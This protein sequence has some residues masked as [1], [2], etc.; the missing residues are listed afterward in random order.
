MT[1]VTPGSDALFILPADQTLTLVGNAQASGVLYPQAYPSGGAIPST[2][3][4][5]VG[6]SG[7]YDVGPFK[8]P[9]AYRLTATVGSIDFAM[10]FKDVPFASDRANCEEITASRV[11]TNGD[12]GKFFRVN[13]AIA[14][15]LTIPNNLIEGWN[16]G[17]VQYGAGNIALVSA[18]GAINRS[19]ITG[20]TAQYSIMSAFCV[21]NPN[22]GAAAEYVVSVAG[23]SSGGA[24]G[25]GTSTFWATPELFVPTAGNNSAVDD[26]PAWRQAF[27][28]SKYVTCDGSKIYYFNSTEVSDSGTCV[29]A[30]DRELILDLTSA[31]IYN[32]NGKTTF[33]INMTPTH[34]VAVSAYVNELKYLEFIDMSVSLQSMVTKISVASTVGFVRGDV[35][36]MA[37]QDIIT[38]M[39][40]SQNY[41][42]AEFAIV[43]EVDAPN[44]FIWLT[45]VLKD[46]YTSTG[47]GMRLARCRP[48]KIEIR[49]GKLD[50]D[51]A[52]FDA[53]VHMNHFWLKGL[54]YPILRNVE[55]AGSSG[56][57]IVSESSYMMDAQQ[58][59]INNCY[60]PN[61]LGYG[62][63][64]GSCKGERVQ[65]KGTGCRHIV[66]CNPS[67]ANSGGVLT[68]S[69]SEFFFRRGRSWDTIVYSSQGDSCRNA[70]FDMHGDAYGAIFANCE[71]SNCYQ[72]ASSIGAGFQIA[73]DNCFMIGCQVRNCMVGVQV[74]NRNTDDTPGCGL[75]LRMTGCDIEAN[76]RALIVVNNNTGD[77]Q[78]V[79]LVVEGGRLA[80]GC[81]VKTDMIQVTRADVVFRNVLFQP[82]GQSGGNICRVPGRGNVRME[83]CTIDLTLA[84]GSW[85]GLGRECVLTTP[86]DSSKWIDLRGR[87]GISTDRGDAT[88][89]MTPSDSANQRFNT[90]LTAERYILLPAP[91]TTQTITRTAA[92]TGASALNVVTQI[93]DF[94]AASV[95][96]T[97]HDVTIVH[98]GHGITT[99]IYFA[100]ALVIGGITIPVGLITSGSGGYTIS[101]T[102]ANTLVITTPGTATSTVNSG[103]GFYTWGRIVG[104]HALGTW[105]TYENLGGVDSSAWVPAT[106]GAI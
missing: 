20:T 14:V 27:A 76:D 57:G 9:H 103:G 51:P 99:K 35:V 58:L 33:A 94:N 37:S 30:A 50:Y 84:A 40:V 46:V 31:T 59:R 101:I 47:T 44:N 106:A 5:T 17:F 61:G 60:E 11:L 89:T 45:S 65:V 68:T 4:L 87:P 42:M 75:N 54:V 12:N 7:S 83:Q 71:A 92:A 41:R 43:G 80:G 97:G 28:A 73:G 55:I 23:Q 66:T 22:D 52:L 78:N 62:Y 16:A 70:A 74:L 48:G 77:T 81:A 96:N 25:G 91:S 15:S 3:L 63:F 32:K 64:I 53:A 85:T 10:G 93:T 21:N 67:N 36:K 90:P 8:T 2:G 79:Q 39:S 88:V 19:P 6:A 100:T 13:S 104:T 24:G 86:L 102:N 26:C 72:G 82:T 38:G 69:G 34:D 1:S 49:G 29:L 105:G 95:V 56:N 98:A 18:S